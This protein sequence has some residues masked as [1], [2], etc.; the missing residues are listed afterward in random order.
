MSSKKLRSM[1]MLSGS[2]KDHAAV[3]QQFPSWKHYGAMKVQAFAYMVDS[4]LTTNDGTVLTAAPAS[5][6]NIYQLLL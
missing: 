1:S 6:H 3:A 4:Q 2:P 5:S